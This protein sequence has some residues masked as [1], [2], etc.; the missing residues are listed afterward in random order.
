MKK[1][2]E[3]ARTLLRIADALEILAQQPAQ[4]KEC[5]QPDVID[6]A[7]KVYRNRELIYSH[8]DS[9]LCKGH[10]LKTAEFH[11]VWVRMGGEPSVSLIAIARA[12]RAAGFKRIS[13]YPIKGM[14]RAPWIIRNDREII[15]FW[16]QNKIRKEFRRV[17]SLGSTDY[18]TSV[19]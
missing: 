3:I 13:Q 11:T 4:Q 16:S 6:W 8:L 17:R 2:K 1:N 7:Y 9:K 19:Q 18:G 12:L 5:K 14:G 10:F 15:K